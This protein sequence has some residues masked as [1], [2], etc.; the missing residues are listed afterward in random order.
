MKHTHYK[1]RGFAL[2]LTAALLLSACG[3]SSTSSTDNGS[4]TD[5]KSDLQTDGSIITNKS[6]N[7]KNSYGSNNA[8][9]SDA[10]ASFKTK[11]PAEDVVA[12]EDTLFIAE[13]DKGVEIVRIGYNDRID[14]EVIA[15]ISG[16]NATF[17]ALS[18]DRSKLYVQN[19]EG[20][21]NLFDISDIKNPQREGLYTANAIKLSPTTKDGLYEF[22]TRD[23]KGMYIYDISNPSSKKRIGS[24]TQTPVYGIVLIDHDT[25]ALTATKTSGIDLLDISNISE[26]K[27][28][29]NHP[30]SGTTLGLSLNET[31]GVLFVANGDQGVK[32]FNLNIF[33]DEMVTD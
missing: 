13:G 7:T 23:E 25:K 28:V 21:V 1:R 3:G 26:I 14:H 5:T 32:V 29:G 31:R 2:I 15:T 12:S 10:V 24:Y 30:L 20:Y 19:R 6:D 18:E 22:V 8:K 4:G 16:V 27:K 17:V 11:A 9:K 33:L